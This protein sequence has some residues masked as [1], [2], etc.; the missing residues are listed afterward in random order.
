[1]KDYES[2]EITEYGDVTE[3]TKQGGPG[4]TGNEKN[5]EYSDGTPLRGTV[6]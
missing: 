6:V 5:D 1:M 2:P 4:K 3:V